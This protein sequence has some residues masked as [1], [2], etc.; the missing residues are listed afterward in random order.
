MNRS[1]AILGV[2]WPAWQDHDIRI[3][4]QN[5]GNLFHEIRKDP[6]DPL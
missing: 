3:T 4:E 1:E 2:T 6:L 5:L